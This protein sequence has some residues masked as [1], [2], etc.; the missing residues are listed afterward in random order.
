MARITIEI[1]D[2][3]AW[4]A[5]VQM[6]CKEHG[7]D[8]KGDGDAET[9]ALAEFEKQCEENLNRFRADRHNDL[10]NTEQKA[11]QDDWE[12]ANPPPAPVNLDVTKQQV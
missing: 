7:Y 3:D 4:D 6:V 1:P 12:A 8:S 2:G 11:W 9:F 10:E 5:W